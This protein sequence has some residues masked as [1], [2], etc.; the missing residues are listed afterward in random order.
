VK[1]RMRKLACSDKLARWNVLGIQGA[2]MSHVLRP[3][4][5]STMTVGKT[6]GYSHGVPRAPPAPIPSSEETAHSRC[7]PLPPHPPV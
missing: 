3:I 4:Y 1:E 2:L 7:P 5:L 6:R